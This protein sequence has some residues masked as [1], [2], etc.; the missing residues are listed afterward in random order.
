MDDDVIVRREERGLISVLTM[1]YRPYNL[2]GPTL[3]GAIA[4]EVT[5]AHEAASRAIILRSGLRPGRSG[6]AAAKAGQHIA[7]LLRS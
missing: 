1:E 4:T 3:I 2:L 5:A 6:R 7:T